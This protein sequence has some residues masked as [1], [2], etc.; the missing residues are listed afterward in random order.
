MKPPVFQLTRE[1]ASGIQV[2]VSWD[3]EPLF[4]IDIR[5]ASP[6]DQP[7]A[8]YGCIAFP[9]NQDGVWR[10]EFYERPFKTRAETWIDR[11]FDERR[12]ER[13]VLEASRSSDS[14][15]E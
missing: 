10:M 13:K 1:T 8:R 14:P 11:S 15:A 5:L 3:G 7:W 9:R 6:P 12:A 2:R 4:V